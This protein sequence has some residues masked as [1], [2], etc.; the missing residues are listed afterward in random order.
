M[1]HPDDEEHDPGNVEE[2]P[3]LDDAELEEPPLVS[4]PNELEKPKK[5][6]RKKMTELQKQALAKGRER[7]KLNQQ[8]RMLKEREDKMKAEGTLDDVEPLEEKPDVS[9]DDEEPQTII[10]KR[11]KKKKKK[12]KPPKIVC[13]SD[14]SSSSDDDSPPP[15]QPHHPGVIFR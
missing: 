6:P 11:K 13:Y 10:Y 8:R 7:T 14:S 1:Q 3:P 9:S 12:K 4:E 15:Q 5:K 2:Q